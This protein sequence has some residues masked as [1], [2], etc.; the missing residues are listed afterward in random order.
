[1]V[2]SANL[3]GK[4]QI[5]FTRVQKSEGVWVLLLQIHLIHSNFEYRLRPEAA[6]KRP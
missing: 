2:K 1:M 6:I 4:Q 3:V 5:Q